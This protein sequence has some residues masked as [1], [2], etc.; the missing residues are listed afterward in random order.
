MM[1]KTYFLK[2]KEEGI[3]KAVGVS[4]HTV[5]AVEVVVDQDKC[6]L[7][8]YCSKYCPQFRIKII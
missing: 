4:T 1:T 3:L 5:R 8:G 6:V 7:C 2:M